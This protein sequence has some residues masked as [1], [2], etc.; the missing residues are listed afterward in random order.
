MAIDRCLKVNVSGKSMKCVVQDG[1]M[2][3]TVHGCRCNVSM[4]KTQEN[5]ANED[6][7]C[8]LAVL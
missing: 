5:N 8:N 7:I 3:G 4:T 6:R 1:V 2:P